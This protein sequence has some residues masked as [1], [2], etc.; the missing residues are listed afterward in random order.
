M[1]S[2]HENIFK[3]NGGKVNFEHPFQS[4]SLPVFAIHGNHDD[5]SREG[6]SGREVSLTL[7]P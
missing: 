7:K 6:A 1:N 3:C 5:P 2:E 4:V